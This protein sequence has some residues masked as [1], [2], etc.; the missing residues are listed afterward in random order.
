MYLKGMKPEFMFE[1]IMSNKWNEK[2]MRMEPSKD[3]P[4][5]AYIGSQR[6]PLH[7]DVGEQSGG[8]MWPFIKKK[9]SDKKDKYCNWVSFLLSPNGIQMVRGQRILLT[10]YGNVAKGSY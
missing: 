10:E 3:H 2:A 7:F 5:S 8:Y 4:W 9:L 1:V 6:C